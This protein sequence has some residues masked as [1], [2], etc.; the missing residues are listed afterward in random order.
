M[1]EYI[2]SDPS[3]IDDIFARPP[4]AALV[5]QQ[6]KTVSIT[7]RA[8]GLGAN[9][10]L[11]HV[12]LLCR[13]CVA[14]LDATRTRHATQLSAA[15]TAL[16]ANQQEWDTERATSSVQNRWEAVQ[17]ALIGVAER[18]VEKVVFERTWQKRLAEGGDLAQ[19]LLAYER[20][21]LE[22][23]RLGAELSRL[24]AAQREINAAWL[25]TDV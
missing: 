16:D 1:Q 17:A 4:R 5:R 7:C 20:Y 14:D 23:D 12:A 19:L 10:P 9:V 25:A 6:A 3:S 22:C 24:H 15:L 21:V 2:V 13:E 18:R 8:C 11:D